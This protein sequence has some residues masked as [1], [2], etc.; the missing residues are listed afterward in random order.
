MTPPI[1]IAVLDGL[2]EVIDEYVRLACQ[3][4]NGAGD[5]ENS[6]KGPRGKPELVYGGFQK[7]SGCYIDLAML[8][9]VTTAHLSIA[10]NFGSGKA[11]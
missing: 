11:F 8:F 4:R 1:Q 6:V 3:I 10:V 5:F 9:N 2:G 7:V